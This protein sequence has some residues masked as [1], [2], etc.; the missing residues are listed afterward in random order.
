MIVGEYGGRWAITRG[1]NRFGV[2]NQYN[3]I[4]ELLSPPTTVPVRC[5]PLRLWHDSYWST[6]TYD[7]GTTF[8]PIRYDTIPEDVLA[9]WKKIDT[10]TVVFSS[11]GYFAN[12]VQVKRSNE[13]VVRIDHAYHLD[14]YSIYHGAQLVYTAKLDGY[15]WHQLGNPLYL[16]DV[17]DRKPVLTDEQLMKVMEANLRI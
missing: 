8:H 4:P 3:D 6:R 14:S 11:R 7:A 16:K 13:T 17:T 5:E 12:A 2:S 1:F 10:G 15:E 9:K